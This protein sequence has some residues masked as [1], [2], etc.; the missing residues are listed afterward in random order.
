[1]TITHIDNP[2]LHDGLE[3]ANQFL[4]KTRNAVKNLVELNQNGL[5]LNV[6]LTSFYNKMKGAGML[7]L[8]VKYF[9]SREESIMNNLKESKNPNIRNYSLFKLLE[10]SSSIKD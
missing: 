9:K 7:G 1:M 6:R 4:E 3:C 2:V 10:Y 5:L 8:I